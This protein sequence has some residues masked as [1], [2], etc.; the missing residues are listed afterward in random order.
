VIVLGLSGKPRDLVN[1]RRW[2]SY[3]GHLE[4]VKRFS[5]GGTVVLGPDTMLASWVM[6]GWPAGTNPTLAA[7]SPRADPRAIMSWSEEV[8]RPMIADCFGPSQAAVFSARENDY[9]LG[10]VKFG[11]N[12]QAI[13]RGDW[14][15]HTSFLWDWRPEHMALLSQPRKQPDYRKQ[16]SHESF[17][18]P[19][20]EHAEAHYAAQEG[21]SAGGVGGAGGAGGAD[22]ASGVGRGEALKDRFWE[23]M[24]Q[25][26]EAQYDVEHVELDDVIGPLEDALA[27]AGLGGLREWEEGPKSKRARTRVLG[28]EELLEELAIQEEMEAAVGTVK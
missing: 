9:V 22:A 18:T 20:R 12:A 5:G 8:Y 3:D 23:A 6:R 10:D 19:L 11:G 7:D 27:A 4:V 21:G 1:L 14:V 25:T 28:E 15:H 2:K 16:R 13:T 17:L 26:A 24:V